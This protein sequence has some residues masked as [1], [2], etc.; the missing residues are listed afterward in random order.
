MNNLPT[1]ISFSGGKTSAFM[2]KFIIE[3]YGMNQNTHVVFANTGKE[4]EETLKFVQKCEENWG[5]KIVWIEGDLSPE[6]GVGTTFKIVDFE[7]ASRNG[8]PFE[9][10]IKKYGLPNRMNRM[11]TGY[12]KIKPI[13]KYM[14]SLGYKEWKSAIGIR[15]DEPQRIR[16]TKNYWYPLHEMGVTKE[17]INLFWSKQPFN[18]ELKEYEGNCDLCHLKAVSKRIKCLRDKPERAYWWEKME[19]M[20]GDVFDNKI[21]VKE[22]LNASKQLNNQFSLDLLTSDLDV[23]CLCGD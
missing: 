15:A 5:I 4:N 6:K 22:L 17:F 20:R 9:K 7:T 8:E 3:H 16:D 12:L 18:L 2:T 19:E 14:K 11:C 1:L 23:S 13:E 10:V 21:S